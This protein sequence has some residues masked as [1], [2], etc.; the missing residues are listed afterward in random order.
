VRLKVVLGKI[1]VKLTGI[2]APAKVDREV[3]C[4]L[5]IELPGLSKVVGKMRLGGRAA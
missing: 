4:Y 2:F 5:C 1:E 3:L